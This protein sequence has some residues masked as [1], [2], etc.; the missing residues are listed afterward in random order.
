[1]LATVVISTYNRSDALKPTLMAL[2][3]QDL[4][5]SE[6]EVIV[7]DDGSTDDTP[8]VLEAI[9][10]PYVLR[11]FRQPFNQGVSAGRN[12]G[13]RNATGTYIII[14]SDDLLVPQNFIS[15]HVRTLERFPD[16]WVVGGFGQL[17]ALAETPFGRFLEA[18]ERGFERGRTGRRVELEL[19]E[20]TLPTARNLS[21]RRSDLERVGLFDE[22][23][24]VTC[25][26]Q[27]LAQRAGVHGIRF[28]YNAALECVHSDQAADLARYCRFQERG[29][30]DTV[31]LC[32]KYPEVHGG[33]SIA[34]VNGYVAPSDGP[35]L[36]A[37]K[38]TKL[39]LT[40]PPLMGA[41]E[42][43]VRYAE[44][45]GT[46]DRFLRRGYRLVIGLYMFR[47]FRAGLREIS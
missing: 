22:R 27:D 32:A 47:G 7:V 10:V 9:S 15:T 14:L 11:T 30:R 40:S 39:L 23:F 2:A 31:R 20:M 43:G 16:A 13:L 26:D 18:L 34:R 38:L 37:R 36:I 8:A 24:R 6:Y 21:L 29:A 5:P 46:S 35:V 41:I 44:R 28:L 17:D 19:Y 3:R 1:V 33:A 4:R 42:L 45:A 12:I 25:E